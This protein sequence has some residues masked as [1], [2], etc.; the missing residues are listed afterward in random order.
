MEEPG[1]LSESPGK[2]SH[3]LDPGRL[4]LEELNQWVQVESGIGTFKSFLRYYHGLPRR[5]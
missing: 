1:S 5:H 4:S 2:F 3:S